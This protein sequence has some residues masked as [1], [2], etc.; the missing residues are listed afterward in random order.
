MII[1]DP[2]SFNFVFEFKSFVHFFFKGEARTPPFSLPL[3]LA[4]AFTCFHPNFV[5]M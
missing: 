2:F 3:H 5:L 1:K 4:P